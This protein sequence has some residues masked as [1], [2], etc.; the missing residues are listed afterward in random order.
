MSLNALQVA[1]KILNTCLE[2][3]PWQFEV[4]HATFMSQRFLTILKKHKR[5]NCVPRFDI[6]N[7]NFI[8]SIVNH[9]TLPRQC[10]G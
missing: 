1:Y 10:H 2:I 4:K 7:L 3:H 5:G 6:D 9:E 8:V